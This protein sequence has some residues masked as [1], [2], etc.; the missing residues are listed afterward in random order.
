M[1]FTRALAGLIII[2]ALYLS[3]LLWADTRNQVFVH[4]PTLLAMLPAL[5]GMALFSYVI[6]YLRWCWLLTRAGHAT[7]WAFGFL[8]YISGFA[9]TATPG[10]VGELVRVRYLQPM[11]VAPSKV[12]GAFIYERAFDLVAVLMLSSL[13]LSQTDLFPFAVTF[14]AALLASIAFVARHPTWLTKASIYLRRWRFRRLARLMTTLR[15][16]L[17]TCRLWM[18]PLDVFMSLVLGLA[19][20]SLTSIS[21]V[22][23][24]HQLNISIPL[25]S[26]MAIYPLAM[27][28]GAASMIPGGLG[29]TESAIVA[30]LTIFGVA[31]GVATMVAVGIRIATL[32]FAILCGMAACSVLEVRMR[33]PRS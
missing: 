26:A 9:F 29:S 30:L 21:F 16:G 31:F 22:W 28:A 18:T 15:D 27:L 8:A 7:G 20:W 24:L 25:L 23:L 19:A 12:L 4:F 6:R 3:A 5:M 13:A 17:L 32:W 11:G 1:K 33:R 10:K 2:A 14:V